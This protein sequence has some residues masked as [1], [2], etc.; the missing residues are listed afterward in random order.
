ML[1]VVAWQLFVDV[2]NCVNFHFR[3][4]VY[5]I[6]GTHSGMHSGLRKLLK[7]GGSFYLSLKITVFCQNEV[8]KKK[9]SYIG[10]KSRTQYRIYKAREQKKKTCFTYFTHKLML[11]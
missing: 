5:R 6:D 9:I 3:Q 8:A 4:E 2:S 7:V 10:A 1:L 11:L